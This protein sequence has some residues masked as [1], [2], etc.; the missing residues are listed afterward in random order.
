MSIIELLRAGGVQAGAQ[1]AASSPS[2]AAMP[3]YSVNQIA[4]YLTN[5]YW[6]ISGQPARHFD[7]K[8]GGT[9][10]YSVSSIAPAGKWFARK[11]L[12]AWSAASG[13]KFTE[14]SGTS[15]QIVFV[16]GDSSGAYSSSSVSFGG[17]ISGSMVNIPTY[18]YSGDEYDLSSYSYQ[19]YLHEIGHA[20]GLGH[21][22]DYN[23]SANFFGNAHYANDSWQKTVMSY[24]SQ[25]ENPYVSAS[26]AYVLTPMIADVAAIQ[27]LYGTWK[28]ANKGSTTYGYGSNADGPAGGFAGESNVAMTVYDSSGFDTF[29]FSNYSGDQRIDLRIGK[30][31]SVMGEK[32][33]LVI[34]YG[35]VIERAKGGSGDDVLIGNTGAN[36][37]IGGAG[38]DTLAGGNGKDVLIGGPGLDD[39]FGGDGFDFADYSGTKAAI[40]VNL[41]KG[42]G[43]GGAYGDTYSRIEGVRGGDGKDLLKGNAAGNTLSGKDSGDRLYGYKGNDGLF[44]G[45]GNDALYGGRG[46]DSLYGG[47]GSDWMTGGKGADRFY[48]NGGKDRIKDFRDGQNDRIFIERDLLP[49][50][51]GAHKLMKNK[52]K[53]K[54]GDVYI[55]LGNGD[56]LIVEDVR[57]KMSLVDD[58]SFY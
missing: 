19:T 42:M 58:I 24:F 34:A 1:S 5:G 33:N 8:P 50:G 45:T 37:L 38:D 28:G 17:T 53:V 31:S 49:K 25:S 6:A 21:A 23:G 18:W 29:N 3:A 41:A 57:N 43:R 27:K 9:L 30:A 44:G 48:F 39:L 54:N 47:A 46:K 36:T 22:G 14:V 56:T 13:I 26:F 20:L 2:L 16:Q 10:T 51:M 15:A 55:E 12:D 4:S 11:A 40:Y 35:T 7:V 52:A 32:G